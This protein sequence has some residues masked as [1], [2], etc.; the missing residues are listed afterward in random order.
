MNRLLVGVTG[1]RNQLTKNVVHL[2]SQELNLIHINMRQPFINVL[3]AIVGCT[4]QNAASLPGHTKIDELKCTVAAFERS[5][6]AA[7]YELNTDYFIDMAHL[8]LARSTAGFTE[9]IKDIFSGH[10]ISGI[11]RPKEADFIRSRG[12]IL[13]HA[14]HGEGW[15]DFHPIP[16]K[17]SDIYLDAKKLIAHDK[18]SVAALMNQIRN[19]DQLKAA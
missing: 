6:F 14:H 19:A 1:Q 12:G 8:A 17:S 4:P 3:A 7:I 2:I 13:V 10:I 9:S 11:S 5:F 18:K 16:A 15:T